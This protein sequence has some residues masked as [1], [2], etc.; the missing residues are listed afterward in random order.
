MSALA[1]TRRFPMWIYW[2]A[3]SLIFILALAPMV[4]AYVAEYIAHANDCRLTDG[5][6]DGP[7]LGP[8]GEDLSPLLGQLMIYAWMMILTLPVGFILGLVW[9]LVLVVHRMVCRRRIEGAA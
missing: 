2:I 3:L 4:S 8:A 5:G 1:P 6:A 7:C 9:R